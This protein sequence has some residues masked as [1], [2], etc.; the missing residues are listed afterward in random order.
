[1]IAHFLGEKVKRKYDFDRLTHLHN[2]RLNEP[3]NLEFCESPSAFKPR[4]RV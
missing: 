4:A 2:V 1:M 3:E